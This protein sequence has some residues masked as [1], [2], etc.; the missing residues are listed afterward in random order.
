MTLADRI[1]RTRAIHH[2]RLQVVAL[3]QVGI[4][5]VLVHLVNV[6]VLQDRLHEVDKTG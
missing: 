6:V 5:V 1:V 3:T 4:L 2:A